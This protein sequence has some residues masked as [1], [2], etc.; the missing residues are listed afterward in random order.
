MATA[1]FGAETCR[2]RDQMSRNCFQMCYDTAHATVSSKIKCIENGFQMF[3]QT[4]HAIVSSNNWFAL[5]IAITWIYGA[6]GRNRQQMNATN[7]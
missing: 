2:A 4:A 7:V 6:M 3:Y 1:L 5:P